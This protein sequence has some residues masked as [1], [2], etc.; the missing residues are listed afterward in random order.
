MTAAKLKK[1]ATRRALRKKKL[2]PSS[3]KRRRKKKKAYA[4]VI[5]TPTFE[6]KSLRQSY[7][8]LDVLGRGGKV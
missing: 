3:S 7:Q 8:N 4:V 2:P 5:K 1:T 6:K